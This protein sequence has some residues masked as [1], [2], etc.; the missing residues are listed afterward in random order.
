MRHVIRLGDATTHGGKVIR[1]QATHIKVDGV[2]VA[3]VGDLCTCPVPGHG[4]CE[5]T[6][7]SAHHKIS[8]REIA[9]HGDRLSCGATLLSS[10]PHFGTMR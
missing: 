2:P 10:F 8:G 4:M 1:C 9:F 3:C 5:I 6:S 7:G